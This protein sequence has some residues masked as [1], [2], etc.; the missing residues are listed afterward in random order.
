LDKGDRKSVSSSESSG[1]ENRST[2]DKNVEGT[3][4]YKIDKN[5]KIGKGIEEKKS[6][7]DS[8]SSES[9]DK[10][11]N[12]IQSSP[13]ETKI[14]VDN[15]RKWNSEI[16]NLIGEI[17]SMSDEDENKLIKKKRVH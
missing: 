12:I 1:E 15:S 4:S 17:N 6:S 7:N 3:L 11:D 2:N 13:N 5:E 8:A 10:K 9:E 16:Q 14:E